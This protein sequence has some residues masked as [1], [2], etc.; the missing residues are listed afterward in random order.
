METWMKVIWGVALVMMLFAL[1]PAY[2]HWS[3]NSPKAEKGD[4]ASVVF[5]MGLVV[6]FVVLLIA[7]VR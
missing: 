5:V 6:L 3:K 1:W 7:A 2:K 4:W